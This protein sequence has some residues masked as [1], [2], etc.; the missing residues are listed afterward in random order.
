MFKWIKRLFSKRK[1]PDVNA[2]VNVKELSSAQVALLKPH[3]VRITGKRVWTPDVKSSRLDSL[4]AAS[5]DN[6][7]AFSDITETPIDGTD[8][9]SISRTYYTL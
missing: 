7:V 1:E 2:P 8:F 6:V 5:L 4:A 9:M 3:P